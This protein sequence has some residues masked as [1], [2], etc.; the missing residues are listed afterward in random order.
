MVRLV[1]GDRL[2][3]AA[4][5]AGLY[6]HLVTTGL[7]PLFDG[8]GHLVVTPQD[9]LPVIALA[10]L[11]G[12]G[13]KSYARNVLFVLPGAWLVGGMVGLT[14]G[15]SAPLAATTVSFLL[16][17]GLVALDRPLSEKAGV[18]LAIGL[19][20]LHGQMTGAEMGVVGIGL[21]GLLGTVGGLF[22]L[23]SLVT[24]LVVGLE[25]PWTRI[26]VR[27][28]GS[29]IVAIGLLYVGWSLRVSG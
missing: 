25:R 10:L 14:L 18:G 16:L 13:G 26:A 5:G 8:I 12:L 27:V 2:M 23:V 22:V 4:L 24:G 6:A 28:A 20:L 1:C 21:V 7:G 19:G 17:G 11:A 3:G 9:L 15:W 29:W